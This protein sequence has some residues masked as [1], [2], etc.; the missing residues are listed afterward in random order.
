MRSIACFSS[1]K[2][3]FHHGIKG[4]PCEAVQSMAKGCVPRACQIIT[5]QKETVSKT[6]TAITFKVWPSL[7]H[8]C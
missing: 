2:T 4:M 1:R 6:G 8:P 7:T 3:L 5:D